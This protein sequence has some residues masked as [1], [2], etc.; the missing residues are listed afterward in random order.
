[1]FLTLAG[2][3]AADDST[4]RFDIANL[5]ASDIRVTSGACVQTVIQASGYDWDGFDDVSASAQIWKGSTFVDEQRVSGP[6]GIIFGSFLWCPSLEGLG[7]FRVGPTAVSWSADNY[8]TS[9]QFQDSSTAYF[10]AKQVARFSRFKVSKA[11]KKRTLTARARYFSV[12]DSAWVSARKGTRIQVQRHPANKKSGSWRT[13][14]TAKVGKRGTISIT[15][16]APKPYLYRISYAGDSK[17]WSA[18]SAI[19]RK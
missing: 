14:R 10:V 16:K 9:G 5:R 13:I 19:V 4:N 3:A 1:M 18:Q 12:K 2:P 7:K 11:G 17:T 15:T 8:T 6:L